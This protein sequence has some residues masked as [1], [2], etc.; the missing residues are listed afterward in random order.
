M[1]V[2]SGPRLAFGGA[3]LV[4]VAELGGRDRLPR[5]PFVGIRIPSTL[6]SDAAWRAGH[7]AGAQALRLGGLGAVG[8]GAAATVLHSSERASKLL[9]RASTVSLLAGVG[10]GTV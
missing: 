7:R 1:A 9:V 8:L 4:A 10:A 2:K 6:R 3:V 5:Q